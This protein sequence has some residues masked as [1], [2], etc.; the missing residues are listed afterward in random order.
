MQITKRSS[1]LIIATLLASL[2]LSGCSA[3]ALDTSQTESSAKKSNTLVVASQDYYSNEII[4]ETYAQALEAEGY[5][6][7]RDMRIGQREVYLPEITSGKID[8]FPEYSGPLLQY[9]N[10]NTT[11]TTSEDVYH[12]LKSSAP[13]HLA[14]LKQSPATDQ[15]AY[16][17]TKS[18]ADKWSLTSIEDLAR[19][20]AAGE[21]ITMGANSEAE[22][23]PNG[24]RG[25]KKTYGVQ[26]DFAPIEDSG[27]PLTVK[28]LKD[29]QV[30]MAIMYTGNPSIA[31]NNLVVLKDTK[32]LFLSSHIVP[33]ASHRLDAHAVE[34]VNKISD[35]LTSEA[36]L[37]LNRRS[38]DEQLSAHDIA[39]DWLKTLKK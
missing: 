17:V 14:I 12:Q 22:N 25:L 23:R 18:F 7:Q 2:T 15:D 5:T 27:G 1:T 19:V 4:A 13:A 11:V 6:V 29:G 3:K 31:K 10:K 38:V 30:Q 39:A 21:K 24:P 35:S 36:L 8:L 37:E 26:A 32:G 28:A 20:T 9:W 34:T 16:V 33:V